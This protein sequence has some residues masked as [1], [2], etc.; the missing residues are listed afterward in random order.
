VGA[1]PDLDRA[2]HSRD[3]LREFMMQTPLER[4]GYA[5]CLRRLAEIAE[6]I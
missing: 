2:L 4:V 5:D 6:E 3:A 1:D